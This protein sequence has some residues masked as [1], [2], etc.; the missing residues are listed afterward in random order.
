MVSVRS[1]GLNARFAVFGLG[2]RRFQARRNEYLLFGDGGSC[3]T[4]G[5]ERY[6]RLHFWNRHRSR[7]AKMPQHSKHGQLNSATW[8]CS[9]E[10][11][12][13]LQERATHTCNPS[14]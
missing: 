2:S 8:G 13:I 7:P 9:I 11:Q 3:A 10:Q 5:V 14:Q 6:P 4:K 12:A 1:H